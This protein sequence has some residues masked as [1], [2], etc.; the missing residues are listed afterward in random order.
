ML[1]TTFSN[2]KKNI[3]MGA[4]CT[5]AFTTGFVDGILGVMVLHDVQFFLL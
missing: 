5:V 2:V 4:A 1:N 3:G